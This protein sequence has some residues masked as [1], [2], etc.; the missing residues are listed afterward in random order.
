MKKLIGIAVLA[1]ATLLPPA[2]TASATPT[3]ASAHTYVIYPT[4][5]PGKWGH[6]FRPGHFNVLAGGPQLV[7]RRIRWI[8]Y[9]RVQ[10]TGR[11]RLRGCDVGCFGPRGRI[12][13]RL[14]RA[15]TSQRAHTHH[16]R[17]FTRLHF[18]RVTRGIAHTWYWSW[19]AL[20]WL[21]QA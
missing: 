4:G 8:R 18:N 5:T 17:Y 16:I 6:S 1:L 19:R 9:A 20:E 14:Y 15:R 2:G 13:F 7:V 12:T 21:P 10:A 3:A 11:G